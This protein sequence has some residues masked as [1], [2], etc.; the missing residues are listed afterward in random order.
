MRKFSN[1]KQQ[2]L[3]QILKRLWDLFEYERSE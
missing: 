3:A 1:N 2:K